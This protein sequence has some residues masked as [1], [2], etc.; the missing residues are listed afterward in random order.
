MIA[1]VHF[2]D[3]FNRE[4]TFPIFDKEE[5]YYLIPKKYGH[6]KRSR[7][8]DPF[9]GEVTEVPSPLV[10][11]MTWITQCLESGDTD[12]YLRHAPTSPIQGDV[13]GDIIV[14]SKAV[15]DENPVFKPFKL[16]DVNELNDYYRC[17]D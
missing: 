4:P 3:K 10:M 2:G 9:T 7:V 1:K 8:V 12:F 6:N 16:F 5:F 13:L 11:I 15:E 17:S 14:T